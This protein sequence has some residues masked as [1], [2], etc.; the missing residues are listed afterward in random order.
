MLFPLVKPSVSPMGG[1]PA[2]GAPTATPVGGQ[3]AVGAQGE[4]V[5]EKPVYDPKVNQ[6]RPLPTE[7]PEVIVF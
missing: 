6:I 3:G 4:V 2:G 5:I 1:A 7:V